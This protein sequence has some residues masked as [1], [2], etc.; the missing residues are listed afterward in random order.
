MARRPPRN[1]RLAVVLALRDRIGLEGLA[2]LEA[3]ACWQ[4][5]PPPKLVARIVREDVLAPDLTPS[6]R[7]CMSLLAAGLTRAEIADELGVGTE[8]V[9]THLGRAYRR[10]GV[11]NAVQAVNVFLDRG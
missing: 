5:P 6:Q 2:R 3:E 4:R 10:L 1:E 9:K 11:T 8:T 7:R